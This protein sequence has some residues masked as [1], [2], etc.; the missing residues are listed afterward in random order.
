M[1]RIAIII[2]GGLLAILLGVRIWDVNQSIELPKVERYAIGE[3]VELEDSYWMTESEKCEGYSIQV[4]SASLLT[5]E[6]FLKK[7][8]YEEDEK[9]L[10]IPRTSQLFPDMVYDVEITVKNTNTQDKECG[11]D[12][13]RYGVY[14]SDFSLQIASPLYVIANPALKN[15]MQAFRLQPN[16]EMK[17]HLPYG[18]PLKSKYAYLNEDIIQK[19]DLSLV[20][21]LYPVQKQILLNSGDL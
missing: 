3:T 14:A 16:T 2:A 7:Y 5:Y 11:I 13:G 8:H 19:R 15:G 17:F 1:K 12:V 9:E 10:L 4:N 21:S 20:I 6:E 18:I